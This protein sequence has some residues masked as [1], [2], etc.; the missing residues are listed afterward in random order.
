MEGDTVGYAVGGA[1]FL[2]ALAQ[3]AW[4]RFFSAPSKAS[5]ALYQQIK[6]QLEAHQER[7]DRLEAEVDSERVL[8]RTA[9]LEAAT[10]KLELAKHGI[11]VPVIG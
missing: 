3:M 11:A 5:E 1:G 8:R 7:I 6:E 4:S 10:Y 2:A 9:Q